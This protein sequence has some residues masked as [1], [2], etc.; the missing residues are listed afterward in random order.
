MDEQQATFGSGCFWCGEAEFS[1]LEG[2]IRVIPG[3]SGGHT[4]HPTYEEVCSGTTG[5]AEVFQVTFDPNVISYETLVELFF[6]SH[7]PTT[8][9]RQG[10]DIGSQYRSII[11]THNPE[12]Q[13]IAESVRQR[14][15]DA[16]IFS[17]PIVTA[18]EPLTSFTPA[19]PEH[20]QYFLRHP[21]AA[22]CQ[23]VITP[24]LA[25]FR[26]AVTRRQQEKT[27]HETRAVI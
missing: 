25:A 12:Q 27:A 4:S 5:H 1:T 3:Y 23:V 18:I 19:E 10:H 2:V 24:K 26:S 6:V 8:M 9:N 7:D 21:E 13:A 17:Q 22:Y 16:E 20:Q 11:L 14:L 15:T